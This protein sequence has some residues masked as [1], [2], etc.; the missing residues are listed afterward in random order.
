MRCANSEA[1]ARHEDNIAKQE[2]EYEYML[3]SISDFLSEANTLLQ[4][5]Q[6]VIDESNFDDD[7]YQLVKE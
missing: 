6:A 3:G 4:Q 7:A 2:I 1:L 5:A